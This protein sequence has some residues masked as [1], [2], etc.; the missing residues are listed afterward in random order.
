MEIVEEAWDLR[1]RHRAN[2]FIVRKDLTGKRLPTPTMHSLGASPIM[3]APFIFSP[4]ALAV[5]K[6]RRIIYD[7]RRAKYRPSSRINRDW[8]QINTRG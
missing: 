2:K 6:I 8:L 3:F 1:M 5:I 7:Q 4:L